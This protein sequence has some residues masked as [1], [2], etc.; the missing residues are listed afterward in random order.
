MPYSDRRRTEGQ[1][2]AM[3]KEAA[4]GPNMCW[5]EEGDRVLRLA[6]PHMHIDGACRQGILRICT[7]GRAGRAVFIGRAAP[8]FYRGPPGL[9]FPA[10]AD[11]R[12]CEIG[13]S[14]MHGAIRARNT[15]ALQVQAPLAL[16][17][18]VVLTEWRLRSSELVR[19]SLRRFQG[20]G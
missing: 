4:L 7:G 14:R 5:E 11:E 8:A 2:G 3:G 10:E 20:V 16:A 19:R 18:T 17:L 15:R 9:L 1:R 13:R 12:L 6:S